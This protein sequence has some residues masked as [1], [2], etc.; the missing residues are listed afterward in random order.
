MTSR[1]HAQLGRWLL[2]AIRNR[3]PARALELLRLGADPKIRTAEGD[4]TLCCALDYEVDDLVAPL[5]AAGVDPN[6]PGARGDY[7]LHLLTSWR[8][9]G[10]ELLAASM[11]RHGAR[12]DVRDDE[13]ATPM[14]VAAK[15]GYVEMIEGLQ[16]LGADI[17]ETNG[18]L[19]TALTFAAC[20]GYTDQA[21]MLLDHGIDIHARDN[22]GMNAL[23]W[24]SKGGH[25]ETIDLLLRHGADPNV[26]DLWGQTPLMRAA[27]HGSVQC[28][29]L[30]LD[31]G[32]DPS[33][34]SESGESA[35]DAA[36]RYAGRDLAL[37]LRED[38]HPLPDRY[39]RSAPPITIRR[40]T[41]DSGEAVLVIKQLD[42]S[43]GG[44]SRELCDGFDAI[45][46]LLESVEE[47]DLTSGR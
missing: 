10:R 1:K 16:R 45:V 14:F 9:P 34:M 11:V 38:W 25:A 22:L 3:R 31:A 28:V 27:G 35:L 33:A 32:A 13:G 30:P 2:S 20:W 8:R 6:V 46:G 37:A 47:S 23:A 18:E 44:I 39:G 43:G 12:V 4:S 17:S 29:R 21:R 41:N 36:K 24:A 5:L 26:A 7:P 15:A 19:D 40:F 42:K